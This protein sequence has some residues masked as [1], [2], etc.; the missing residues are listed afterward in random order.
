MRIHSLKRTPEGSLNGRPLAWT[1]A[2]GAWLAMQM[3][4]VSETWMTG[5]G[6]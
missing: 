3:R 2:P 1:R 5:L 6:S 4:A